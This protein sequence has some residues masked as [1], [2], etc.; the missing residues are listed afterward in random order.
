VRLH[1][2]LSTAIVFVLCAALAQSAET[3]RPGPF[4]P[5][6]TGIHLE[7]V[8][9]ATLSMKGKLA[10]ETGRVDVVWG[11]VTPDQPAGV[12]NSFYVAVP[13]DGGWGNFQTVD[14]YRTNHP[15]W[16]EYQ[17]DR[18]TLAFQFSN[19]ER[20][21]LDFAN[22]VVRAYQ[23]SN[24]IDPALLTMGY[25]SIAVDEADLL[26]DFHRCGHYD[27]GGHW[28]AQYKGN[29]G[30]VQFKKDMLQWVTLTLKHIHQQT[31]FATMQLNAPYNFNDPSLADNQALM[32]ATDLLFD[33]VGFTNAGYSP[34]VPTPEEWQTIV[35]QIDY[36][37]S[38]HICY[39]LN[40]EE[41]RESKRIT[42]QERQWAI[43]N[44]LLVKDNCT[45]MYMTGQQQYGDLVTFPEYRIDI[46]A[47]AG[48]KFQ[49]QGVW[50]RAYAKGLTIV[51]PSTDG[52]R[53]TLPD[54]NW[55]DVNGDAMGPAVTLHAQTGL[56]LLKAP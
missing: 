18:T 13:V 56:V 48:A 17:C 47:P 20:A 53:V 37:Q 50:E 35:D 43:A 45:Y 19:T 51:N 22:P 2:V 39:M 15:D 26:N 21:P 28:V 25:Q 29:P 3:A 34:G 8:F 49:T 32:S 16:L 27:T 38:K 44:Y 31:P 23:W 42:P 5:T 4:P 30:D 54:G 40:G 46:G 33:E 7:M 55:V 9:N 11:S 52:A 24:W 14:W 12:Y 36:L 41:P 1:R 6:K 10:Q